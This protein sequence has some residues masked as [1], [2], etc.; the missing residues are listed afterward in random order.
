MTK[1]F[2]AVPSY[3]GIS[4]AEARGLIEAPVLE[5][6]GIDVTAAVVRGVALLDLA[7][8]ELLAAFYDSEAELLLFQDDD[9]RTAPSSI[10]GMI[11][12]MKKHEFDVLTAPVQM[13]TEAREPNVVPSGPVIALEDGHYVCEGAWTG[14]GSVLV[15]RQCV[16]RLIDKH[17]SRYYRS[18]A[19]PGKTAWNI[20]RSDTVP[21]RGH[22]PGAP[23]DARDFM[24]DDR[25]FSHM[26]RESGSAI[27][28][29]LFAVT[30]HRGMGRY[31]LGEELRKH[32]EAKGLHR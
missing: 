14:L 18:H 11:D 7:R 8:N 29:F 6:A 5:Q 15:S 25:I 16:G 20:F 13:R 1:L 21:A 12:V 27:R 22:D 4:D 9:A 32:E 30:D 26:L 17:R 28:I 19:R 10:R 2:L 3:K 23:E 31:C 24:G